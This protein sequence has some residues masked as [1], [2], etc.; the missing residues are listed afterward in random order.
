MQNRKETAWKKNREW[1]Q[2]FGGRTRRR[3]T[4]NIVA[5]LHTLTAPG[6]GAVLPIVMHDNPSSE[7]YFPIEA[8]E[9]LAVLRAL[10]PA[11]TAGITHI[12]LRRGVPLDRRTYQPC[13][14]YVRGSG[15]CALFVLPWTKSRREVLPHG[16]PTG[17][18]ASELARFGGQFQRRGAKWF[19]QFSR[20][21]LRAYALHCFLCIVAHHAGYV[22]GATD[23]S[24]SRASRRRDGYR[25][26]EFANEHFAAAERALA[27]ADEADG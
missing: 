20:D 6:E 14:N 12:V 25:S 21:D 26:I 17:A 2:L 4:D 1:G 5:R 7:L 23:L 16:R 11:A 10:P 3:W 24:T 15:V 18:F 27:L 8:H 22:S 19:V 9:Y 13:C